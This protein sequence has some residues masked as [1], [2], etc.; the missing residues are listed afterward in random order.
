MATYPGALKS[1]TARTDA[2]DDVMADD[3]NTIY[4][5]VTAVQTELGTDPAGTV[6]DV[7]TRLARSLDGVGN[8]DH[9][10]ATT[11]TIA[12]G[13]I[14]PTQN[15]HRVDTEAAAATDDLAT[16]AV[17]NV[18][19]GFRLI[20]RTVDDARDVVVKHGA[21]NIYN[22]QG[23]DITLGTNQNVIE[24]I[25]DDVIDFWLVVGDPI[26]ARP[27]AANLFT[28]EQRIGSAAN[29]MRIS[30]TDGSVRLVGDATQWDDLRIS[31]ASTRIGA[32][33]PTMRAFGPSGNLFAL[34]FDSA[35]HDEVF[36]EIQMPHSW[37]E[38]S[39]IYPHVHWAPISATAGNVVWQLDYSWANIDGAF[40]APATMTG[41]A[42]AAG[43]TAWI[44]KLTTLKSGGNAYISG[45]GKTLSSMLVCRLHRDAGA[46]S[47]TLAEH[48][49]FLEF[50]LHYQV[51]GF[52]S[53]AEYV[54]D[55]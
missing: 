53:E 4:D 8:L 12:A 54:K 40:G 30:G 35:Q 7:K 14:T 43:G 27:N 32:T 41:D 28:A 45:A 39:N 26:A 15:F 13:S 25:Y 2:A 29:Y 22:P 49:A 21:G 23:V 33:A 17:A 31:A 6:S 3:V 48:V 16:I 44:H 9:A 24:L 19:E 1:W 37:K 46:G 50:D 38:G 20:L 11:L 51:D 10:S 18:T 55:A 34:C 42:T 52:G 36:F 47:D 5:E